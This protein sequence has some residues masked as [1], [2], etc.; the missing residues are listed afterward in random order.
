MI[1]VSKPGL[2]VTPL[3]MPMIFGYFGQSCQHEE[4][5]SYARLSCPFP[6]SIKI[7]SGILLLSSCLL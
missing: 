4:I 7:M 3:A 1:S 2:R 6:P 5:I